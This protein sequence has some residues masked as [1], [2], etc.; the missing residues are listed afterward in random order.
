MKKGE[1]VTVYQDPVTRKKVEGVGTI[2]TTYPRDYDAELR[3]HLCRIRFPGET[4][5]FIR[6]VHQVDVQ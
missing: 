5:T 6:R 1:L 2:V 3:L 4:K